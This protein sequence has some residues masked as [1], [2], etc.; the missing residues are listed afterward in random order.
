MFDTSGTDHHQLDS[1]TITAMGLP[2][3]FTIRMATSSA[4]LLAVRP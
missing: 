3:S 4:L 1:L 2:V